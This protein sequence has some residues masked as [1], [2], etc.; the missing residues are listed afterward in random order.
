M[1]SC[2]NAQ[3][4][5]LQLMESLNTYVKLSA[6]KRIR[7][8]LRLYSVFIVGLL[9]YLNPL[10]FQFISPHLIIIAM[11]GLLLYYYKFTYHYS[12]ILALI[13]LLFAAFATIIDHPGYAERF[14]PLT[15]FLLGVGVVQKTA[16]SFAIETLSI[17]GKRELPAVPL[18]VRQKALV[19]VAGIAPLL[20]IYRNW[21]SFQPLV[22]GDWVYKFP[23][24]LSNQKAWAWQTENLGG[25]NIPFLWNYPMQWVESVLY[26]ATNWQFGVIEK[27][28]WF[29]PIFFIAAISVTILIRSL[30]GSVVA[31]VAGVLFYFLNTYAIL[32]FA[33]GQTLFALGFALY[34]F[35]FYV[36]HKAVESGRLSYKLLSGI[37]VALLGFADP[38]I[39]LLFLVVA[40]AYI[41]FR[42]LA[43]DMAH[44]AETIKQYSFLLFFLLVI[45]MILH[46]YWII[47]TVF[48]SNMTS[49]D[50]LGGSDSTIHLSFMNLSHVLTLYAPHWP[51]NIFG[52]TTTIQPIFYLF[53]ITIFS[54]ALIL[55][56]PIVWFF[57][58]ISLLS[59]FLTKGVNPPFEQA[60]NYLTTTL[61]GFDLFRDPSKFYVP[62]VLAYTVI[63]ALFVEYVFASLPKWLNQGIIV[64]PKSWPEIVTQYF[65]KLARKKTLQSARLARYSKQLPWVWLGGMYVL[66]L[67]VAREAF[68]HTMQGTLRAHPLQD[69]YQTL[70]QNRQSE[71]FYRSLWIPQ[72]DPFVLQDANHPIVGGLALA[73]M[74]PFN[75]FIKDKFHAFTYIDDPATEELMRIFSIRD[76]S[77]NHPDTMRY[78]NRS[79]YVGAKRATS[80]FIADLSAREHFAS[81]S[82]LANATTFELSQPKPHFYAADKIF[83]VFGSSKVYSTVKTLPGVSLDKSAFIRRETI[84]DLPLTVKDLWQAQIIESNYATSSG[85]ITFSPPKLA[86]HLYVFNVE[87]AEG[88]RQITAKVLGKP[89]AQYTYL[90]RYYIDETPNKEQVYGRKR[91]Y[92]WWPLNVT[93]VQN[94]PNEVELSLP[95]I[96]SQHPGGIFDRIIAYPVNDVPNLTTLFT[97]HFPQPIIEVESATPVAYELSIRE[98]SRPYLLIFSESF[99]PRWQAELAGKKILPLPVFNALNGFIVDAK[100]NYKL[101]VSFTLQYYVDKLLGISL[102]L[103]LVTLLYYLSAVIVER[104]KKQGT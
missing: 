68:F 64:T 79:D 88:T 43:E 7:A 13:S 23:A 66:L 94:S 39:A 55:K 37:V 12:V 100:G 63:F 96:T 47:T 44:I 92:E 1:V 38:R 34:P 10:H 67:V 30:K 77:I 45:P 70:A 85:V 31:C 74:E 21:F 11:W 97:E 28:V 102:I 14:L 18:S 27:I 104:K 54:A 57:V 49:Q 16:A 42:A 20:I 101:T 89:D 61:P 32:L 80:Q 33:G 41:I 51:E 59:A 52:K 65:P 26:A 81:Q 98:A 46:S 83:W 87:I 24:N 17:T 19:I 78:N 90:V 103:G 25:V 84:P 72:K 4:T 93:D 29:W 35:A 22:S 56:R 69:Q 82:A 50:V 5:I 86:K 62:L 99:H 15:F 3:C 36:V 71:T 40:V 60:Y 53:P 91:R 48:F 73:A 76:V 6:N 2:F 75:E 9:L 58:V 8:A 95:L